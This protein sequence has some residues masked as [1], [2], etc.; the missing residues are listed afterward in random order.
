LKVF[1]EKFSYH[2]GYLYSDVLLIL[3]VNTYL[4]QPQETDGSLMQLDAQEACSGKPGYDLIFLEDQVEVNQNSAPGWLSRL[5][6][7]CL[8]FSAW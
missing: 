5:D 3:P 2:P 7:P 4:T 8:F 6:I 1:Q